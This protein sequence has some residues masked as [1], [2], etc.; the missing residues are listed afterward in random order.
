MS[1]RDW[2]P[3]G[4][5]LVQFLHSVFFVTNS[6]DKGWLT[7]NNRKLHCFCALASWSWATS[8]TFRCRTCGTW[9]PATAVRRW[10]RSLTGSG[11]RRS[12]AA[13]LKGIDSSHPSLLPT[14]RYTCVCLCVYP[15][16][17]TEKDG[18]DFKIWRCRIVLIT[19]ERKILARLS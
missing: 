2:N 7:G 6:T 5:T 16:C 11:R 12:S 15:H 14:F 10:F 13:C 19:F 9:T 17:Q 4:V 3:L 18:D 8:G 1:L